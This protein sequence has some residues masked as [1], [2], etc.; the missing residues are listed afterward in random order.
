MKQPDKPKAT[1][2]AAKPKAERSLDN[3]E[4][5]FVHHYLLTLKPDVAAIEAG[6]S[7]TVALTKAYSWVSNSQAKPHVYE[8]IKTA[9]AD[10][11]ER[12]KIDADWVL[13]R[14][15]DEL[16]ADLADIYDDDGNLKPIKE[17]PIIWRQGLIAGVETEELIA[18][19]V[20]IANIRKVKLSDRLKRIE[21]IGKHVGV[22]AFQETV[23]HKGLEGLADRLSRAKKRME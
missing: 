2:R 15:R 20:K 11:S 19:G 4:A 10:R 18:E 12:M 22:N 21:L 23:N 17:M 7:K 5:S 9:I 6:Y 8:A 16:I 14:L 1:K 3:R 13:A